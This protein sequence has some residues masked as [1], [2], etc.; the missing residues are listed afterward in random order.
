MK[1]LASVLL[2]LALLP[3]VTGCESDEAPLLELTG[4]VVDATTIVPV[5]TVAAPAPDLEAGLEE[6]TATLTASAGD[7]TP[8]AAA[9]S[10]RAPRWVRVASVA[11]RPGDVVQPGQELARIDDTALRLAV[12]AAEADVAAAKASVTRIQE[13]LGEVNEGRSEIS[14]K[15]T[16]LDETIADLEAE[17]AQVANQLAQAN[18]ALAVSTAATETVTL[19][20]QIAALEPV[21]AQLDA[22]L[23]QARTGRSAL[24]SATA[25]LDTVSTRLTGLLGAAN[26]VVE[27]K[28]IGVRIAEEQLAN[29][30]VVAPEAGTVVS[31]AM[32]GAV[33]A[34]GAPLVELRVSSA[35]RIETYATAEEAGAM[36]NGTQATVYVDALPGRGQP[37]HV[38]TVS[39]ELEYVPTTFATKVIHL[40]RGVRVVVELDGTRWIAP[41]TPAD[42][43]I[44]VK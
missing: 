34:C 4:S 23:E 2:V 25:E 10:G 28:E 9:A 11:V 41:G 31:A 43:E 20:A 22:G 24:T 12:D 21:L 14:T 44:S 5:P 16:E 8:Q 36:A 35:T 7:K 33:L 26:A 1:R 39:D 32:P 15:T 18:A 42:V 3:A 38:V 27:A 37:A 13:G 19:K 40:S 30:V 17:R 29:A 6:T